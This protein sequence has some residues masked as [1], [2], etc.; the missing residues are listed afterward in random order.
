LNLKKTKIPPSG[1]EL[2]AKNKYGKEVFG[3]YIRRG[4]PNIILRD[5]RG[6][7]KLRIGLDRFGKPFIKYKDVKDIDRFVD[8]TDKGM[9]FNATK[10]KSI[11]DNF[12][13]AT[14]RHEVPPGEKGGHNPHD[15]QHSKKQEPAPAPAAKKQEPATAPTTKNTEPTKKRN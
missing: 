11:F 2:F 14:H 13:W 9:K 1:A 5:M 15:H 3:V 4:H 10:S 12:N 7:N 6:V 8:F